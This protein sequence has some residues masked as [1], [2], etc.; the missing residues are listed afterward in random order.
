MG[1]LDQP[2]IGNHNLTAQGLNSG[3]GK[4][5][6]VASG[7]ML[8]LLAGLLGVAPDEQGGSV[9]D[10]NS[11]RN[12]PN[13]GLAGF[14]IGSALQVAPLIKGLLAAAKPITN[15]STFGRASVKIRNPE[16]LP[17]RPFSDDYKGASS[18]PEI[19]KPLSFDIEGRRLTAPYIAGRRVGGGV[20]EG[21]ST[22]QTRRVADLL[23]ARVAQA[24]RNG[25][26]L[27]GDAGRYSRD[28]RKIFLDESMNAD[29][30]GS[31]LQHE[32]GHMIEDIA[33][34]TRGIHTGGLQKELAHVYDNLNNRF[35]VDP[36][37]PRVAKKQHTPS[38]DGYP[39][40]DWTAERWAEAIRAYKINPNYFKTVA[41]K[42]A[43]RIR[44]FVNPHPEL[45]KVIQFNSV[46]A[47]LLGAGFADE[48]FP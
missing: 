17:Q 8:A 5:E 11:A 7:P 28:G 3:V 48:Q 31:V 45:S 14:G 30:A 41:P 16:S 25:P 29:A 42:T 9:L 4:R 32:T 43:A 35:A 39:E 22:E 26:D 33:G 13:A 44:E 38:I 23:G 6:D 40:K 34:Y 1:L 19:G 10:P 18:G 15:S 46:G 24:P 2:Y 27:M 47:G 37:K 20:D 12:S 36:L 21:L